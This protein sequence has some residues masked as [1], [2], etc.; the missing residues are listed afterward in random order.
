[1]DTFMRCPVAISSALPRR[2]HA[3]HDHGER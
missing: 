2:D 3:K 1:M